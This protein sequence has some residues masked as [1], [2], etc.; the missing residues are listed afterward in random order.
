MTNP[1][2][3][4]AAEERLRG[5]AKEMYGALKKFIAWVDAEAA[6]NFAGTTFYQ[7]MQMSDDAVLAAR[8]AIDKAEGRS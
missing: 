2:Q 6:P 5:A 3:D 4:Y 8:E 7:R 1:E